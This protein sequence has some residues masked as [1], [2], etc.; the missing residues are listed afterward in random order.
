MAPLLCL[1]WGWDSGDFAP[2]ANRWTNLQ[3]PQPLRRKP[4]SLGE[5]VEPQ[6]VQVATANPLM[7]IWELL[8][9]RNQPSSLMLWVALLLCLWLWSAHGDPSQKAKRSWVKDWAPK[10]TNLPTQVAPVCWVWAYIKKNRKGTK[11]VARLSSSFVTWVPRSSVSMGGAGAG[12]EGKLQP[13]ELPKAQQERSGWWDY[14]PLLARLKWGDFLP[15]PFQGCQD[16]R[17][18]RWDKTAL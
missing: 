10:T 1:T 15:L 8:S 13:S 4:P 17:V 6:E 12:W 11:L 5:E 18:V 2:G 3:P 9:L 14:P 7:N 16:I